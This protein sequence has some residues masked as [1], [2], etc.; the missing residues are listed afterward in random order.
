MTSF[1]YGGSKQ[2]GD[3]ERTLIRSVLPNVAAQSAGALERWKTEPSTTTAYRSSPAI[4]RPPA[5]GK[6]CRYRQ[7]FSPATRLAMPRAEM[8]SSPKYNKQR[9]AYNP[10]GRDKIRYT[11]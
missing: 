4:D 2:K 10:P 7:G 9:A 8:P 5:L 1:Q 11:P 3:R 6:T